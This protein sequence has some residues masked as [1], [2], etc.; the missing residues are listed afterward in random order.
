MLKA[1]RNAGHYFLKR[2]QEVRCRIRA[3]RGGGG[4]GG[5]SGGKDVGK[6]HTKCST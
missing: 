5:T 4:G 3:G 6:R 1:E 2:W